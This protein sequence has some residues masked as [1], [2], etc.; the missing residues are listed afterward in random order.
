MKKLALG[1]ATAAVLGF[2][3]PALATDNTAAAPDRIRLAQADVTV[4]TKVGHR[5]DMGR[6]KIVIKERRHHAVFASHPS[7][8]KVIIKRGPHVKKKVIIER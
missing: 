8:K 7:R 3:A 4:K 2:A 5:H 6:K 1:L